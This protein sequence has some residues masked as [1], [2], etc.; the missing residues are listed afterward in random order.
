[1][2]VYVL[3]GIIIINHDLFSIPEIEV[4]H[5]KIPAEKPM[6]GD[7][8]EYTSYLKKTLNLRGRTEYLKDNRDNWVFHFNIPGEAY[9]VN[10]TPDQDTLYIR[11]SIQDMNLY[12]VAHRIHIVRGFKRGWE[13]T[14]WAVVYDVTCF[15]M[16]IFA[17]TGILMWF[18]RRKRFRHGWWY[19]LAGILIPLMFI[20]AFVLWK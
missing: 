18:R 11:R 16:L 5:S 3:T 8:E 14:A 2:I 9:Q 20:Y 4:N 6:N 1:M 17:I 7:P 15:A 10:L 19:L 12:T 13:Y